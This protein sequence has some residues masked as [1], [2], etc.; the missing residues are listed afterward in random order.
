MDKMDKNKLASHESSSFRVLLDHVG[1]MS[2]CGI[3]I[4]QWSQ[5]LREQCRQNPDMMLTLYKATVY[6]LHDAVRRIDSLHSIEESLGQRWGVLG[7]RRHQLKKCIYEAN[8]MYHTGVISYDALKASCKM[9][10]DT[11]TEVRQTFTDMRCRAQLQ[12]RYIMSLRAGKRFRTRCYVSL[13]RK[14]QVNYDRK[15]KP[16]DMGLDIELGDLME[17]CMRNDTTPE[18]YLAMGRRQDEI[19]QRRVELRRIAHETY[20]VEMLG[21]IQFQ[22]QM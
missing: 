21:L 2:T 4:M 8:Q 14:L 7:R 17:M 22:E 11:R 6:S 15:W 20:V 3:M 19:E 1:A 18:D 16:E 5:S 10:A 13:L 12:V 9:L